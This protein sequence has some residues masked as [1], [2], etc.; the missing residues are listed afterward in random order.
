ML[1][2]LWNTAHQNTKTLRSRRQRRADSDG[3]PRNSPNRGFSVTEEVQTPGELDAALFDNGKWYK[4]KVVGKRIN[5]DGDRPEVFIH[6]QGWSAERREWRDVDSDRL[7]WKAKSITP[8]S[9]D[10]R[11][12]RTQSMP[13]GFQQDSDPEPTRKKR[14]M[15]MFGRTNTMPVTLDS[16]SIRRAARVT[17]LE[18]SQMRIK[19]AARMIGETLELHQT[20]DHTEINQFLSSKRLKPTEI[21]RAWKEVEAEERARSCSKTRSETSQRRISFN[22]MMMRDEPERRSGR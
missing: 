12:K 2:Q 18:R 11:I 15:Q 1:E 19:A 8:S 16:G 5:P 17:R 20:I 6:Y 21:A 4:A 3:S 10:V 22:K 7:R 14:G 9:T 13:V